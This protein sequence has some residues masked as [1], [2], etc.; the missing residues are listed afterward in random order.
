MKP[1][2]D[3]SERY[4][5]SSDVIDWKSSAIREAVLSLVSPV[6]TD[7]E[8]ARKL[9]EFVRDEIPHSKDVGPE[10]VTCNAS[11]VLKYGTGICY[12]KSHLLAAMLRARGIPA[13]FGY[14]LLRH[15]PPYSGMVVHGFNGVFLASQRCW[16]RVDCRGNT[17][18][19]NAQ[20]NLDHE[21]LAFPPDAKRGEFT[22]ERIFVAPL[23][24]VI[25]C[26]TKSKSVT[27]M[28]PNLPNYIPPPPRDSHRDGCRGHLAEREL[29]ATEWD[30]TDDA[31]R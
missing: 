31:P 13:G 25:H 7:V 17:G 27:S 23:P 6:S 24:A 28:W 10:V 18:C 2:P 12:A 20:F 19:I 21:Q 26:L 5:E 9:F 14:Q 1:K 16:I 22:D 29:K 4:L 8:A 3:M 30:R 11:D 15:G